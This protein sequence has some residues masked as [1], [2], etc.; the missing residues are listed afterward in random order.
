MVVK[1]PGLSRSSG[2]PQAA[3]KRLQKAYDDL[4]DRCTAPQRRKTG[5]AVEVIRSAVQTRNNRFAFCVFSAL[6]GF[7][8]TPANHLLSQGPAW[9]RPFRSQTRLIGHMHKTTRARLIHG[10]PCSTTSS[11]WRV[12]SRVPGLLLTA[13]ACALFCPSC[14]DYAEGHNRDSHLCARCRPQPCDW[15]WWQ[16][17]GHAGNLDAVQGGHGWGFVPVFCN[18]SMCLN[19]ARLRV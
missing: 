16:L 3:P 10:L 1:G 17:R 7:F 6:K 5:A 2:P 8:A 4:T 14:T 9:R 18:L 15:V 19:C 11:V 13:R 12:A